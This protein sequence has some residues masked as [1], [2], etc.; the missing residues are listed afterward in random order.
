M[1]IRNLQNKFLVERDQKGF[2]IESTPLYP[3]SV[4]HSCFWK[5]FADVFGVLA[6]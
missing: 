3:V 4:L 2:F 5:R 1:W 6:G